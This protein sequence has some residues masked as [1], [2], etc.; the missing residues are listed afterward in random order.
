M[1][2]KKGAY[3]LPFYIY[4]WRKNDEA[5]LPHRILLIHNINELAVA[6][7]APHFIQ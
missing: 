3:R 2:C 1:K 5:A 7:R 4:E 6:L